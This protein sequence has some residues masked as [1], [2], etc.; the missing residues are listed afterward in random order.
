MRRKELEGRGG[1]NDSERV[2]TILDIS[3]IR[4]PYKMLSGPAKRSK[5]DMLSI[6]YLILWLAGMDTLDFR[7]S[8]LEYSWWRK[9]CFHLGL[10][11]DY[12]LIDTKE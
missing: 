6:R 8:Y 2:H 10:E 7:L 4:I 11:Y 12:S 3:M 1:V 5:C 9:L